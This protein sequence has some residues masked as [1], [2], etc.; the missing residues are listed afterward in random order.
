M[1]MKHLKFLLLG[2][3]TTIV[4]L[5]L[6]SFTQIDLGLVISRYPFFYE[7]EKAFQQIGYFN[8]PL[9]AVIYIVLLMA[10]FLFYFAFLFYSRK[11]E[12]DKKFVW[13]TV[14][15]ST[16]ILAFSYN[17][18]SYDLFNYM[19][20]AKIVTH[21]QQNPYVQKALDYPQDPMLGFMHWTH[22]VYPYGPLWLV[23]TVPLSFIGLQLFLPTFFLFKLLMG[24]AFLGSLYFVGKIFQKIA[25]ERELFGLIFFGL[26]PLL[27]NESVVSA[28]LD[29]VMM[30]FAFWAYFL[31]L[32]KKYV[33]AFILLLISIGIKFAS[34]F[35]LPVFLLVTIMHKK[36]LSLPVIFGSSLVLLAIT[37]VVASLRTNFQP[38]YLVVPL[39]LAVF[40]AHRYFVFIPTMILSFAALLTYVPYLYLGNWDKPVPQILM[41]LY[42]SAGILSVVAVGGYYTYKIR[43]KT[44]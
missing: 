39:T 37:V 41:N 18:F 14:I 4:L 32:N 16:A 36:K 44:S 2:Y 30:F 31:L 15:I 5:F 43:V 42:I 3:I 21:Y 9:S 27:L 22:R 33:F 10:M 7:L 34:G 26:N 19:F 8:R 40:L 29:I 17:A 6:Y 20:D 1:I 13:K 25:P 38:W 28:Q 12:V 35:L 11:K 24:A 23:M